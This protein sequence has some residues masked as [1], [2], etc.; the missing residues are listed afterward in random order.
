MRTTCVFGRRHIFAKFV[1][2]WLEHIFFLPHVLRLRRSLASS[3]LARHCSHMNCAHTTILRVYLC[4]SPDWTHRPF[5]S[6]S[7]TILLQ[8]RRARSH[9]RSM[10]HNYNSC[11]RFI[12]KQ[13]IATNTQHNCESHSANEHSA[14]VWSALVGEKDDGQY[15]GNK[16]GWNQVENNEPI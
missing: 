11:V 12:V 7:L 4:L 6:R 15:R 2:F 5:L 10:S 16:K 9:S 1:S 3:L 13:N 8:P 14:V